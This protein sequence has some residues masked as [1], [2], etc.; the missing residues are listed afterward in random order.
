MSREPKSAAPPSTGA[1]G[2]SYRV[3]VVGAATLKGKEIAELLP[4]SSFPAHDVKLL[5]DDETLGQ[6]ES[7]GEEVTFVQSVRPENFEQVDF[8][9]FASRAEFT[10]KT[11]KM[12]KQAGSVIVDLSYGLE[13]LPEARVRSPWLEREL[14]QPVPPELEPAPVVAAHPAAVTLALLLARAGRGGTIR[15]AVAS[16]FEPASE[17]G[18]AGMDE[19][20]EQTVNLLSFQEIPRS[21]FDVQVAFNMVGRY[22]EK[23]AP[24]LQ[25]AEQRILQ[26]LQRIGGGALG[27]SPSLMLLQAPIFHGH[28]F[29]LYVEMEAACALGV[30]TQ[31]L[32]GEHVSIT[33]LAEEYPS[34]VNVAGQEDILLAVRA[35]SQRPEAF[36]IWAAADNLRLQALNALECAQ[37]MAAARP[38]GKLQ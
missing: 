19:L 30:F 8:T 27:V 10:R 28:A 26:H 1:G 38:R 32:T 35:D 34:N 9:F 4:E 11:W 36:W 33:P 7:V 13:D 31:S 15:R 16:V 23:S 3:A 18:R 29:S 14:R 6:L 5:D 17:H 2:G 12:A 21:I 20:H 24:S 37:Q 22:G 25:G